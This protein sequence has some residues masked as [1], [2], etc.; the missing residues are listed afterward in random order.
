M[1]KSVKFIS[2]LLACGMLMCM[3]SCSKKDKKE[4]S[5]E[6]HE[7]EDDI[8]EK[9][10]RTKDEKDEDDDVQDEDDSSDISDKDSNI[11]SKALYEMYMREELIP[12][13][14]W[15]DIAGK[16]FSGVL[17]DYNSTDLREIPEEDY[18]NVSW[19]RDLSCSSGI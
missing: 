2:L 13:L 6:K 7:Q 4:G 10:R 1:K 9:D 3:A 8:E 12:E 17:D 15:T 16:E 18:G 14:G 19:I 11:N 5:G